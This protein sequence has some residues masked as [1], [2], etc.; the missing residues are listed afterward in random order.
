MKSNVGT[1]L[2]CITLS[3]PLL[4][5]GCVPLSASREIPDRQGEYGR[6]RSR[7]EDRDQRRDDMRG[8]KPPRNERYERDDRDERREREERRDRDGRDGR[9]PM[10][11]RIG[12]YFGESHRA[13]IRE[14]YGEQ[15]RAGF[16]PPGLAKKHNGCMPPGQA[17]TW[18]VG[19]PL[20]RDVSY[21]PLEASVQVRLGQPPRGYEFVR[22]ASDI[23]LIAVGTSVVMDAIQDLGR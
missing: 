14:H 6:E 10:E 17:R 15:E 4:V 16:C 7:D 9:N 5:I 18:A 11:P 1:V 20:P 22:V 12:A 23:L 8:N 3:L 19:Q 2:R 21:Y 13:V